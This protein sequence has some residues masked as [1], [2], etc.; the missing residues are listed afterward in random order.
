VPVNLVMEVAEAVPGAGLEEAIAKLME[1]PQRPPA[2]D[3]CPLMF[4]DVARMP[5]NL[6]QHHGMQVGVAC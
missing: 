6:V 3:Q 1:H 2:V 4:A 5:A